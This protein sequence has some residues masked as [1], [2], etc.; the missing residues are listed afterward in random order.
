[1]RAWDPRPARSGHVEPQL[2]TRSAAC[3]LCRLR[4][5]A[6]ATEEYHE[7]HNRRGP[8]HERT[9]GAD[10]NWDLVDQ[11]WGLCISG[12]ASATESGS[13]MWRAALG[14][15]SSLLAFGAPTVRASTPPPGS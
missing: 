10:T 11:G 2:V 15:R 1:M 4:H 7:L 6:A 13:L 8:M 3:S 12:S 9:V 5:A 14:W